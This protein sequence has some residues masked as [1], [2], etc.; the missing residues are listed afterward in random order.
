MPKRGKK[1]K[2]AIEKIEREQYYPLEDGI[3]LACE[4]SYSKF[5]ATMEIAIRLGVDPRRAE[6]NVRGTVILPHGTGKEVKVL[7]FAKG[8]KLT[9]AEAA[10]ADFAGGEDLIAKIKE[11]WLDFDKAIATPDMMAL[12]GKIG[13]ILGP[14]GMMPNPKVG[15]VTFD[16]ARAVRE[17]KA[18][19]VEF[20]V[21]KAGNIHIP[22]GKIS[23]GAEKLKDNILVIIEALL[24]AKPP[25]SKGVYLKNISLSATM[26]PGVKIDTHQVR[27]ELR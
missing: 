14:R 9:E 15:T 3:Q 8:E 5:D 16:I 6:Q 12:V 1:Y 19:K 2:E 25:S 13:K 21:E 23:F 11:G 22:A 26:G 20:R 24:K 7:A 10:G 4:S 17:L 27:A 18:G